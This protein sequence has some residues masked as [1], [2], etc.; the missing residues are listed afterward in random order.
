MHVAE[1][2]IEK[3]KRL[4]EQGEHVVVLLDSI[5]SVGFSLISLSVSKISARKIKKTKFVL[6]LLAN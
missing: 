4:V 1:F 6:P 2:V 5:C 3:A